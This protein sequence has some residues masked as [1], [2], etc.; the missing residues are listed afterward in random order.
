M[1][2]PFGELNTSVAVVSKGSPEIVAG[3]RV[4]HI[5]DQYSAGGK[6]GGFRG[7]RQSAVL[8]FAQQRISPRQLEY[9]KQYGEVKQTCLP[10]TKKRLYNVADLDA[11]AERVEKRIS[12]A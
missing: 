5:H 11:C 12:K 4:R 1:S 10:N 8:A 2:V 6:K 7:A 9:L 3:Q